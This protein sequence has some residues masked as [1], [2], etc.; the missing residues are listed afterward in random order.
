[1]REYLDKCITYLICQTCQN[2]YGYDAPRAILMAEIGFFRTIHQYVLVNALYKMTNQ[3]K[4]TFLHLLPNKG[5]L[6]L[7][8]NKTCTTYSLDSV[9]LYRSKYWW[10]VVKLKFL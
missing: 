5:L 9:F 1:M 3:I 8:G 2:I 4:L 6:I 10:K 7:I